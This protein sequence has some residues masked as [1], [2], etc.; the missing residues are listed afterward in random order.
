MSQDR[1]L[2][3]FIQELRVTKNY[4]PPY[5]HLQPKY[6]AIQTKFHIHAYTSL[7]LS[8]LTNKLVKRKK[9]ATLPITKHTSSTASINNTPTHDTHAHAHPV[10]SKYKP[11]GK[12]DSTRSR[13][14]ASQTTHLQRILI[15]REQSLVGPPPLNQRKPTRLGCRVCKR[16]NHILQQIPN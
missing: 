13:N 1:I 16:V 8:K 11:S 7:T 3:S 5:P 14:S 9:A 15:R 4:F 6:K 10:K 12:T 2:L